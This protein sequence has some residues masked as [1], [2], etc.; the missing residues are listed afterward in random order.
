MRN[1]HI[2]LKQKANWNPRKIKKRNEKKRSM[3]EGK[4]K[5]EKKRGR[6]IKH[7]Q[8]KK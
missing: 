6:N 5:K 1:E 2:A 7:K 3:K 8:Q 4:G